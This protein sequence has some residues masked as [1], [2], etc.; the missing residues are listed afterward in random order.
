MILDISIIASCFVAS[1]FFSGIETALL[2]LGPLNL[3]RGNRERLFNLY[4]QK[5]KL[6][7]TVLI[8]NNLT[9]VLAALAL[10]DIL[11]EQVDLLSRA[12]AFSFEI[13]LFFLIA[14]VLPKT[15]S[16]KLDLK[17]LDWCYFPL[18]FFYYLFRPVSSLF[19]YVTRTLFRIVPEN[20][21][22]V[23]EDIFYFLQAQMPHDKSNV[24][25]NLLKLSSTNAK[26][27]MTPLGI[28]YSLEKHATAKDALILLEKTHYSRYP[29]YEARGDNIV[30][31]IN[32]DDLLKHRPNKRL[33]T[34]MHEA[35]FVPETLPV[36]QLLFRMQNENFP[37][38]F[39]VNEFG[40]VTGMITLED[41]GEELVGDFESGEREQDK[42]EIIAGEDGV[43]IIEGR[44]DIDDFNL[45]FTVQIK[46]E[47]FETVAGFIIHHTGRIPVKNESF[48]MSFGNF[49]VREANEKTILQLEFV[50]EN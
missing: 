24:T 42:P 33:E 31:Y 23:K 2:S 30:G 38:V 28:I 32:V 21:E 45:H 9:I 25:E 44:C 7:A 1:A 43:Y 27:V 19:L 50:P 12:L 35:S 6:V 36:D 49:E 29:I 22:L 20:R 8:G 13:L 34:F 18:I 10:H 11:G 46:K 37:L 14:E 4:Q 39:V 5:S 3:V 41:I 48:S 47:G 17:L 40:A 16:K 15:I 26:E